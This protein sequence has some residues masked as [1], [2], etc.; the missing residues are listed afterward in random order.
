MASSAFAEGAKVHLFSTVRVATER[1]ILSQV[2]SCSGNESICHILRSL[3]MGAAP[4]PGTVKNLRESEIRQILEEEGFQ[5]G[6]PGTSQVISQ[7][8]SQVS[9]KIELI[10]IEGASVNVERVSFTIDSELIK[11]IV[12]EQIRSLIPNTSGQRWL[13]SLGLNSRMVQLA[14]EDWTA[15]VIGI[16]Q[17]QRELSR[18]RSP[19][20][21]RVQIRVSPL[22]GESSAS[23][24]W[25]TL[26]FTPE[27]RLLT[28]VNGLEKGSVIMDSDI[29]ES[30]VGFAQYMDGAPR[31]ASNVIGKRM[32][33]TARPNSIVRFGVMEDLP[34]VNRGEE[35]QI[36]LLSGAIE[37]ESRGRS[38][39]SG[40]LGQSVDVEIEGSKKKVRSK[41]VA[42]GKVEVSL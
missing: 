30:W 21:R 31:D 12:E 24:I 41:V 18:T 9:S 5:V 35:V 36:K 27:F 40:T 10:E 42:Q 14:S 17:F 8:A 20:V 4:Q 7:A 23:Q 28:F 38:F 2:S 25:G 1:Y 26:R 37:M 6:T 3:D 32:K 13:V 33:V 15:K 29:A 19:F 39:Q 16:E 11:E 22:S 34:L